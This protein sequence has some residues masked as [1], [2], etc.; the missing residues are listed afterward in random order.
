M[1]LPL[2][3]AHPLPGSDI[4]RQLSS[5]RLGDELAWHRLSGPCSSSPVV[6]SDPLPQDTLASFL[7]SR[8]AGREGEPRH[9]PGVRHAQDRTRTTRHVPKLGASAAR[10]GSRRAHC[11]VYQCHLRDACSFGVPYTLLALRPSPNT[12]TQNSNKNTHSPGYGPW[13]HEA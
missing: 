10:L 5:R 9:L 2:G 13:L 3:P 7:W 6:R 12:K 1:E 4:Y 8:I 11:P